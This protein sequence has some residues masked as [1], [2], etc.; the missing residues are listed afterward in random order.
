MFLTIILACLVILVVF[1]RY[2][3]KNPYSH[4]P[5]PK[6]I[7]FFGNVFQLRFERIARDFEGWAWKYGTVFR[8]QMVN[9]P[10]LVISDVQMCHEILKARPDGFSR[11]SG[12]A[13]VATEFKANG[14]F[15]H[16]G[17][18]WRHSR[19]WIATA[20]SPSKVREFKKCVWHHSKK[21]QEKLSDIAER[22]KV[23]L[24]QQ[25]IDTTS[26]KSKFP[27][28]HQYNG[29][30]LTDTIM[31]EIQTTVL[32][33]V[34][35]VSFSWGEEN[36]LSADLLERSK[37]FVSTIFERGFA[38]FPIWKFYKSERDRIAESMKEEFDHRIQALIE[39]GSKSG[40][41]ESG[42]PRTLLDTL[43][44]ST[45]EVD[46]EADDLSEKR[47]RT[48]RLTHSQMKA[49]LLTVVMAGY[50]TTAT[51]M[52]WILYELA[53]NPKYQERIRAEVK[54]VFGDP[55][56]LDID[57][58][59]EI[60]EKVLNAS[61]DRLPFINAMVQE[62]LRLHS[63]APFFQLSALKDQEIQ[64][65]TIKKGTEIFL[66][67][68][69]A[70]LR[71]WPTPEPFKFNPEQWLGENGESESQ[72]NTMSQLGLTF[73]YGPR[74]C[75][76]RHLAETELIVLVA[77]ISTNFQLSLIDTPPAEEPVME[78]ILFTAYPANVHIR[79]EK[80]TD[81]E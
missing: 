28:K 12:L 35:D 68:R 5:G 47:R 18:E 27:I 34:C 73:G 76:G 31:K 41:K 53:K 46:G 60:L 37:I 25:H 78:K 52:S 22:Q 75:P 77:L 65:V 59:S 44:R 70:G 26:T 17:D 3:K 72:I 13:K 1:T 56:Q 8:L 66:L 19:Y 69:L 67:T 2:T 62:T 39:N 63:V 49:N 29:H 21:L 57:Q 30:D 15:T 32:S 7:P 9:K 58:D 61:S 43:M 55:N 48:H 24:E 79:I 38:T 64:G 71:S 51:V 6:G 23:L 74:V 54:Q 10:C 33:I 4:I 40:E 16:E 81:V 36:F 11:G 45:L 42:D 80:Y 14:I 50:E 20:F